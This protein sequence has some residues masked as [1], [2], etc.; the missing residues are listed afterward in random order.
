[1]QMSVRNISIWLEKLN[2]A[3]F[4]IS[5]SQVNTEPAK[6]KS[7]SLV[8]NQQ[9][10]LMRTGGDPPVNGG[11]ENLDL[12]GD[13]GDSEVL[14]R[15]GMEANTLESSEAEMTV[16]VATNKEGEERVLVANEEE[17]EKEKQ[18]RSIVSVRLDEEGSRFSFAK[19]KMKMIMIIAISSKRCYH[20]HYLPQKHHQISYIL[21]SPDQVDMGEQPSDSPALEMRSQ[22]EMEEVEV[23]KDNEEEGEEEEEE[24]ESVAVA[25]VPST[26]VKMPDLG[27]TSLAVTFTSVVV[28]AVVIVVIVITNINVIIVGISLKISMIVIIKY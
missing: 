10:S 27:P 2:V 8:V 22:E 23:N 5:L 6:S 4:S 26:S 19:V 7:F 17:V 14:V 1:M 28:V 25:S 15:S 16:L 20:H 12:G 3:N 9:Q 13:S 21:S 24:V 18:S 11:G